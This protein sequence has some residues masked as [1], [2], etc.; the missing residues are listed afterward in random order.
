MGQKVIIRVWWESGLSSASR[1]YLTT[2][3]RPF[4]H[5]ARLRFVFCDSSLY[6][7]QLS[8]FCLIWRL[9]ACADDI[10]YITNIYSVIELL[11]ELK[12]TVVDT[13]A[14]QNLKMSQ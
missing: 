6:P 8:L 10:G 14:F 12:T 11:H 13:E 1:N 5:Y 4:V 2:F 3:Y 7:K 9:N